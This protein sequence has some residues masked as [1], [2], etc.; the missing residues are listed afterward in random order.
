MTTRCS[1]ALLEFGLVAQDLFVSVVW[2]AISHHTSCAAR[3]SLAVVRL[4]RVVVAVACG[5]R[6]M[7]AAL[8]LVRP[9]AAFAIT[10]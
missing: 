3:D 6:A 2:N 9:W 1:Q 8:E 5:L 10:C 7:Q 4:A